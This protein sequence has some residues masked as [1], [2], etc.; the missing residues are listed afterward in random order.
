MMCSRS[1][2]V[3]FATLV[4]GILAN[5]NPTSPCTSTAFP[6]NVLS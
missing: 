5:S 3:L 1:V 2:V 4:A 6:T